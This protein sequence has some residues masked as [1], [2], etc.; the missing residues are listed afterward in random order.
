MKLALPLV[1]FALASTALA[2]GDV[3]ASVRTELAHVQ[4]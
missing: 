4:T 3:G 2:S 1:A